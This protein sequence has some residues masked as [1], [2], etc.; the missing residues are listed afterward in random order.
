M[1]FLQAADQTVTVVL[2]S[3]QDK[4]TTLHFESG[5]LSTQFVVGILKEDAPVEPVRCFF[6]LH[7]SLL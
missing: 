3:P 5:D 2:N 7:F 6:L 1:F 4:S